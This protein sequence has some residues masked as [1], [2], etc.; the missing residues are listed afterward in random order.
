MGGVRAG[1]AEEGD[2]NWWFLVQWM[3]A[4]VLTTRK[5]I[6]WSQGRWGW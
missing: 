1:Q 2:V 4:V 6:L 3:E 5:R